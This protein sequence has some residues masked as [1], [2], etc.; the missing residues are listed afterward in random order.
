MDA[1][2]RTDIKTRYEV[3]ELARRIGLKSIDELRE[4]EDL[5][6]LP[7]GQGATYV[8]QP[9]LEKGIGAVPKPGAIPPAPVGEL[10][11]PRLVEGGAG[12]E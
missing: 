5:E 1:P 9:L 11:R 7:N 8:P 2:V 6:P 10:G 4:L 3:Y 12:S